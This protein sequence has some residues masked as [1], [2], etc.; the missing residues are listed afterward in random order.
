MSSF[1]QTETAVEMRKGTVLTSEPS[2]SQMLDDQLSCEVSRISPTSTK[3]VGS[4]ENFWW[5]YAVVRK[6]LHDYCMQVMWNAVVYD[7]MAECIHNWRKRKLWSICPKPQL[8]ISGCKD[9]GGIITSAEAVSSLHTQGFGFSC[10]CCHLN[11]H[12]QFLP[13]PGSSEHDAVRHPHC[14]VVAMEGDYLSQSSSMSSANLKDVNISENGRASCS[15][16]DRRDLTCIIENV[17][18]E[19]HSMSEASLT[20]YIKSLVDKEVKRLFNCPEEDTL[21][22][23]SLFKVLILCFL[24]ELCFVEE[25]LSML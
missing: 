6:V 17:E 8:S 13:R 12:L 20:E 3:S 24:F 7:C 21:N 2:S 16:R 15:N 14:G 22:E 23:V 18:N 10:L 5:S 25:S 1:Q 19:L 9:Y 11:S 4:I